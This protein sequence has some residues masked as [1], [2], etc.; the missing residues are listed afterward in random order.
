MDNLEVREFQELAEAMEVIYSKEILDKFLISSW[1]NIEQNK[2][3][4]IYSK[5]KDMS[6]IDSER[7]KVSMKDLAMRLG[8]INGK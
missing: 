6:V 7:S 1:P 3:A 5:L 2:R 4:R 8:L